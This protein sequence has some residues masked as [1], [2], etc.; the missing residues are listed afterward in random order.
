VTEPPLPSTVTPDGRAA[1]RPD[2]DEAPG[3]AGPDETQAA[4]PPADSV[5]PG[6]PTA[7]ADPVSP[8]APAPQADPAQQADPAPSSGLD[9]QAEPAPSSDP[10]SLIGPVPDGGL[11][12]IVPPVDLP[13]P[14]QFAARQGG[15]IVEPAVLRVDTASPDPAGQ[16]DKDSD[17]D[18]AQT[19]AA[20]ESAS[21]AVAQ[22]APVQT[23]L[24]ERPRAEALAVVADPAADQ[25]AP[26]TPSA[27]GLT[28]RRLK[29]GFGRW[30]SGL[31]WGPS[32]DRAET[33]LSVVERLREGPPS[34]RRDRR[35]AWIVTLVL[36]GLGFALRLVG[37]GFP[38]NFIFD[39]TFYPKDAYSL[40][41]Y[42]YERSWVGG[43]NEILVSGDY[44]VAQE[45]EPEA[46]AKYCP[47]GVET[48]T[49]NGL[50]DEAA[51]IVHPQLGK[52]LIALGIKIFG[53][54]AFGWRFASLV[55]GALLIGAV[56]RLGRRLSRSTLIG[57]L[58]GLL[59]CCDGLSFVMSRIGLLDIFQST[60]L[61][62]AV[63]AVVADRDHFRHR[64]ADRIEASGAPDLQGAAG[65]FIFRPWLL[66]AG[67]MFGLSCS[68]KWNSI[69]PLAVFGLLVVAWSVSARRLAGARG[70]RWS[71]LW[72]DGA[73]A[74]LSL[75]VVSV[76]VYVASWFSWLTSAGGYDRDWGQ[77]H[78]EDWSVRLFGRALGSLWHYT[79]DTYNFHT[80]DYI[81]S[82]GHTYGSNPWGW[83]ILLRPIGFDAV[84]DI[85]PGSQGC[86]AEAGST[87]LRVISANGTPLLWWLAALALLA[88]LVWWLAG[89]DWRFG[90]TSLGLLS[91]WVPWLTETGGRPLFFFYAITMIPF[92]AIGLAMALGVVL[93]PAAAGRR[94]FV[95]A[96]IV[97]VIVALIILD[98]AFM[99]P[100]YT[101]RLLTR[102]HWQWRMWLSG[103][104]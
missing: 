5:P 80:G 94:R 11:I 70:R 74:F 18:R 58:A 81:N 23:A 52:W 90:V 7:Q 37:L 26:A 19:M 32:A 15:R 47:D 31:V 75:V 51:F 99:Y 87:C 40:L 96:V 21:A 9:S 1:D 46:V 72:L 76:V 41:Q 95:G 43:A 101:D 103:W 82:V 83:L 98:F 22:A 28:A 49:W 2:E 24:L 92:T 36:V 13:P 29:A 34:D 57:G 14:P 17:T 30:A 27:V 73:P 8:V 60:F 71:A 63:G 54:N 48:C 6:D 62:L 56:V 10:I 61:V 77:N 12:A 39:E 59:I 85:Q 42:G 64:L 44:S 53:F 79:V 45:K 78:P 88:G 102:D 86:A 35:I 66:A 38:S 67:L 50:K 89:A 97:G 20:G 65:G 100:V 91:T 93:G 3:P 55:F 25:A 16:L 84:N 69:Y 68:V 104:I 33:G 4:A